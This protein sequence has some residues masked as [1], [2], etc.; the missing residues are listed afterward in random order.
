M[1]NLFPTQNKPT[2]KGAIIDQ[3]SLLNIKILRLFYG[4]TDGRNKF[5]VRWLLFKL[6]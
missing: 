5:S 3:S 6:F 2:S 4:K 1:T